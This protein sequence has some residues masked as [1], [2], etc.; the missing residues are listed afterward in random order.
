MNLFGDSDEADGAT[1]PLHEHGFVQVAVD[2]P[3]QQL[4]SYANPPHVSPPQVGDWVMVSFGGRKGATS[5]S[6]TAHRSGNEPR[7]IPA[8]VMENASAA[9][10]G[11][12]NIK[13]WSSIVSAPTMPADWL[14]LIRFAA[15]FYHYP[16]GQVASM[17]YPLAL[18]SDSRQALKPLKQALS[19][20]WQGVATVESIRAVPTFKRSKH[21]QALLAVTASM[22]IVTLPSL[23]ASHPALIPAFK[24]WITRGWW[25]PYTPSRT[26]PT[27]LLPSQAQIVDAIMPEPPRS[28]APAIHLLQG[29]TGSG[30]TEVYFAL[31]ERIIAKGQ[32][33]L[34]LMPEIALTPQMHDRLTQRFPEESIAVLHSGLAQ[35]ARHHAL[36]RVQKGEANIVVGT[37]LAVF[38]PLLSL[39]LIVV[40]EEHDASFK[41][42]EQ[43]F[44]YS[45][46]DLAILRAKHWACPIVLGSATPSLESYH[47]ALQGRYILHCLSQRAVAGSKPPQIECVSIRG[48]KLVQGFAEESLQAIDHA[49]GAGE[50]VLVFLNRRGYA[51]T[52]LCEACGWLAGC[53][54]CSANLVLHSADAL[55]RCHHCGYSEP[56]PPAC[57]NCGNADILMRGYGTQKIETFLSAQYPNAAIQRIDR[58][59]SGS[60]RLFSEQQRAIVEGR[61]NLIVGTQMMAKGHDFANLTTVV[62]L[63]AD[64]VLF[65]SDFRGAER[66]FSLLTQVAGRAGRRHKPGRVLVQTAWQDHPLFAPL[67]AHDY[68]AF[69]TQQL[70]ERQSQRLPPFSFQALLRVE[71]TSLKAAMEW[72][73]AHRAIFAPFA[74]RTVTLYDAVPTRLA[75]KAG[76]ERMQMLMESES[77]PALHAFLTSL[78]GYL[79]TL[80]PSDSLKWWL[81]ISPLEI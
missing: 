6:P 16:I 69:A 48:K 45:A 54:S 73:R 7:L 2:V 3:L 66:L 43:A 9:P 57:P 37:R 21:W 71:S 38:A 23:Q 33:V 63:G 65:A 29:I 42:S 25:V 81:D 13:R 47:H 49:L 14:A 72:M 1:M 75:R 22:P 76:W 53:E 62:I 59:A 32:Q 36:L 28:I 5:R 68:S 26:P 58:D 44:S 12:K 64:A 8:L 40:D 78:T 34:L 11:V 20:L 60:Y 41:Q 74:D 17:A 77:R 52:L 27:P 19:A 10:H 79:Y 35:N 18:R 15:Q 56:I 51:T 30:K 24:D 46:R 4:F 61:V 39:G 31:M 70:A 80:P 55:I 67:I 50:Q